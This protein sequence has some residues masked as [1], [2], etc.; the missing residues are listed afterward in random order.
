[1]PRRT[2]ADFMARTEITLPPDVSIHTATK[3][4]LKHQ[5]FGAPV[6]DSDGHLVGMLTDRECFSA[7]ADAAMDGLPEGSVQDYMTGDVETVNQTAS[8]FDIVARF[9]QSAYRKFPVVDDQGRVVGQVSRRDT[10][11]ALEAI[12]D[13]SYLYG[14]KDESPAEVEGVDSAMRMARSAV[15]P[16]GPA[17]Q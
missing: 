2:S 17:D 12:R 8:L 4:L 7:L 11:L 13:N 6:V 3:L 16:V 14:S 15:K 10:L 1:M 9:R 5:L